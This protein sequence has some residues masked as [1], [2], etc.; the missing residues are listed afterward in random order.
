MLSTGFVRLRLTT[1]AAMHIRPTNGVGRCACGESGRTWG[2]EMRKVFVLLVVAVLISGCAGSPMVTGFSASA[3]TRVMVKL[4]PDMTPEEVIGLMGNPDKT[5][6]YRGRNGEPILVY[7]YITE[8][9]DTYTRKWSEANY[10]PLVFENNKL[11]GWGW[12][13]LN[14]TAQKYEFIIKNL[15]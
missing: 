7:L 6:M 11:A 15:Y 1:P 2:V 13:Y 12:N 9:R 5:E 8:G 14:G 4:K 3:H 10:T